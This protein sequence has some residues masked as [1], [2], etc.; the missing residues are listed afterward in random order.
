MTSRLSR[1]VIA[2]MLGA[3]LVAAGCGSGSK[4][5][6]A[7]AFCRDN[8]I[9][10]AKFSSATNVAQIIPDLK[11]NLAT[12]DDFGKKAPDAVKVDAKKLVDAAHAA[13]RTGD[14]KPFTQPVISLA[15]THAISFCRGFARRSSSVP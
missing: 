12:I 5:G 13:I 14:A 15:S 3:A 11:A 9:L 10:T 4:H 8:A 1:P 2:A 6:D 7:A